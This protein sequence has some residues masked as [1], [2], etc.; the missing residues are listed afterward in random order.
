MA[1]RDAWG[2]GRTDDDLEDSVPVGI[3]AQKKS[4]RA[5][6]QMRA[7]V[8]EAGR[9]WQELQPK[10]DVTKLVFLDETWA[11]TNMTR[12]YGRSLRGQ[13]LIGAAPYGHWKTTTFL[14]GLRHDG[15]IAPLVLSG[16]INGP[17]FLTYRALLGA[18]TTSVSSCSLKTPV[19]FSLSSASVSTA[20]KVCEFSPNNG[21]A[22]PDIE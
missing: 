12:L 8:A 1:C 18:M 22:E 14:A 13:R 10:L 17:A 9:L 3:H 5:T 2:D 15:I 20:S 19:G 7:D 16:P 6:E 21:L 4:L 11:K